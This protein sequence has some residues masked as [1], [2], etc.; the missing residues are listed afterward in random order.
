LLANALTH[1]DLDGPIWVRAGSD[2]TGFELSVANLGE[3]IA[4]DIVNQLFQPFT[5]ASAR[6]GQEGLGL[7]LYI[8]SEIAR[9]HDGSLEVASSSEETRFTFRMPHSSTCADNNSSGPSSFSPSAT[10]L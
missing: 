9:A 10:A 5:R 4:P 6:I 8:A 1:G 2:E 3:T 7:G